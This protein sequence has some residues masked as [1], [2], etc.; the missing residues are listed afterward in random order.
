MLVLYV[1]A[2]YV[3]IGVIIAALFVTFGA[4]RIFAYPVAITPGARLLFLPGAIVL[5]PI[6]LL[7][8]LQR[9]IAS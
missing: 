9:P 4:P 5:W 2:L 8:W 3:A 1:L 6:V 7:R